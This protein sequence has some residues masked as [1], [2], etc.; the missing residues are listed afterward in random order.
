YLPKQRNVPCLGI[1][2]DRCNLRP[3]GERHV[4]GIEEVA[5]FEAGGHAERQVVPEVRRGCDIREGH[6]FGIT[7]HDWKLE[8]AAPLE[9][10]ADRLLCKF[11]AQMCDWRRRP[12]VWHHAE[13]AVLI[14]KITC[15]PLQ[16]VGG[17]L[18]GLV[19]DLASRLVHSR[20]AD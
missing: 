18:S 16:L 14:D 5:L 2:L 6:R 4:S 10:G 15:A 9:D 8:A 20:A 19:N 13:D 17:H 7:L 11:L 12:G 1:N 3:V